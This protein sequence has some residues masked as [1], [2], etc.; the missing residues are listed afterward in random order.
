[1]ASIMCNSVTV[2]HP[3][4]FLDELSSFVPSI[5]CEKV[6]HYE[7]EYCNQVISIVTLPYCD[8]V[9]CDIQYISKLIYIF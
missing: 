9:F 8:D 7:T 5:I 6:E 3:C 2:F 1:M 4:P